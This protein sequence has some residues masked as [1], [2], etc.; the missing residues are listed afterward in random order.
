MSEATLINDFKF[1]QGIPLLKIPARRNQKGQPVGHFGQGGGYEDTT[2]V[3]YDLKTD[4]NQDKPFND[5]AI[6][7][8]L[9]K[10]LKKLMIINEAPPEAFLRLGLN[11]S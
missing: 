11:K 4:P 6:E 9:M 1:T 10:L 3:L 2:T 8:D 7:K 5:I